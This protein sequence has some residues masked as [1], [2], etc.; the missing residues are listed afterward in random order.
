MARYLGPKCKLSRREGTDLFL[1]S[2]MVSIENKCKI[3]KIPGQNKKHRTRITEYGNQLREKQKVRRIYG[4]LEKQFKNYYKK[5]AK[6]KGAKGEY[7]LQSL[8]TRLDN[9]VYRMG[10]SVTR[11]EARQLVNHKAIKVNGKIVNIASYKI[12]I[13]DIISVRE[14]S[15]NQTRIKNALAIAN[16][17]KWVQVDVKKMEGIVKYLPERIGLSTDINSKLIVELYSK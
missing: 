2:G 11:A 5:A 17:V 9:I 12:N 3:D 16:R 7:L 13:G 6:K 10:F 8:E 4:I 1:K 15:M 14:K